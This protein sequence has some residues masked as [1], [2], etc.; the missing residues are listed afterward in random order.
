MMYTLLSLEDQ[1]F[2][3]CMRSK[4]GLLRDNKQLLYLHN[5]M[6]KDC[7]HTK[8]HLRDQGLWDAL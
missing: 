3:K 1:I 2:D 8:I 5:N 7:Q 6:Q 4:I